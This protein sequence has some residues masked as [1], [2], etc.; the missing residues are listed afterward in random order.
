MIAHFE[1]TA[2]NF[3]IKLFKDKVPNMVEHFAGLANGTKEWVDPKTREKVKRP[4]YDGIIFHRVIPN[5]MVQ[6][7][8]PLGNGTGGPGY[9]VNDEYHPELTHNKVGI[10]SSANVSRPNTN[11]SQFF[12]TVAPTPFLNGKHSVLGEVIEGYDIVEKIS[13]VRTGIADRPVEEIKI[14]SVKVI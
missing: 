13:L 10:L 7:G 14:L 11:G 6:F 1:T 8:C 3:K 4:F 2:G 9:N 5:F 12:I